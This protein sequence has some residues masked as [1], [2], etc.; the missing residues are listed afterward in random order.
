DIRTWGQVGLK[1]QWA[2][3]PIRLY[4]RNAASGTYGFFKDEALAKGDFKNTVIQQP[5]SS[6][7]VQAVASDKRGI[8]YS[9]IGYK[10]ADVRAVPLAAEAGDTPIPPTIEHAYS[11]EYPLSRS[12]LLMVNHKPGTMLDPLRREF[13]RYVLSQQG[14]ADVV[15]DGYFPIS[16]P[17]AERQ[18]KL[19]GIE[20]GTANRQRPSPGHGPRR[21]SA[22]R[23]ETRQRRPVT[24]YQVGQRAGR[25]PAGADPRRRDPS[26]LPPRAGGRHCAGVGGWHSATRANRFLSAFHRRGQSA[27]YPGGF[28]SGCRGSI[29]RWTRRAH[30]RGS[31][32]PL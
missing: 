32:A 11:D 18:L 6:G 25:V 22:P 4:G 17:M 29:R 31:T 7:L 14:Q 20:T 24:R 10:T 2:H 21:I 12:L 28:V 3:A 8:G 13:V 15:K 5:G 1:S 26:R 16:A 9:G 30:G 23:L 19:L 27:P